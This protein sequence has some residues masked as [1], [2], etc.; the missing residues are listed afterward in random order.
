MT[1]EYLFFVDA[2]LF[3][4]KESQYESLLSSQI[5]CYL[6]YRI[7]V[8]KRYKPPCNLAIKTSVRNRT[9]RF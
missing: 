1:K 7:M 6:I 9:L 2:L 8:P 3:L 5:G 4:D